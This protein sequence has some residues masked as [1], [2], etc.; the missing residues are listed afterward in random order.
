MIFLIVI[1]SH[2]L[3]SLPPLFNYVQPKNIANKIIYSIPK[4][5]AKQNSR[6]AQKNGRTRLLEMIRATMMLEDG[7]STKRLAY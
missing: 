1:K 2:P 7:D 4:I 6:R 5:Y 3:H